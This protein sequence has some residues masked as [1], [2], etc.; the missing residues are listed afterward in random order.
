[1]FPPP[2]CV[3]RR[4]SVFMLA[5]LALPVA[6]HAQSSPHEKLARAIYKELIEINTVDSVGSVTKAA[7][8]MAARFQGGR[9]PRERCE[10]S[11]PRRASR[12]KGISWCDIAAAVARTHQ[13]RFF[14]SRIWTWWLRC[15]RTGRATHSRSTRRT[16]ISSVA[17]RRTTRRWRRYSSPTCSA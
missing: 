6:A 1:M 13:N 16:A 4:L 10:A 14:F 17:A 5:V 12:P 3:M 8:A 11:G 2:R 15:G 7:E 9:I